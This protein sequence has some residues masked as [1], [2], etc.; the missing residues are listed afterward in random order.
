MTATPMIYE[1]VSEA[2]EHLVNVND[3]L[4]GLEKHEGETARYRVDRVFRAVHSVKGGAGFFGCHRIE[5]LAHLMETLLGRMRQER[6]PVTPALIDALLAGTDRILT[7]LDDVE[8]SNEAEIDDV[9]YRLQPFLGETTPLPASAAPIS[10]DAPADDALDLVRQSGF[11]PSGNLLEERPA[12]HSNLY[13]LHADLGERYR[14]HL[15][16][17]LAFLQSLQKVGCILDA[18]LEVVGE[19][20]QTGMPEGP[21]LYH[22]LFSSQMEVGQLQ[23]A[24][25]LRTEEIVQVEPAPLRIPVI[26]DAAPLIIDAPAD[27]GAVTAPRGGE[28]ASSIRINV[29]LLD[30]LMSLAGEL[31][32]LRNRALQSMGPGDTHLRPIIQRLDGVTLQLQETV[33]LTRM[34]PVAILFGKFPRLIRDL[35]RQLDKEIELEMSGTE[36]ELDKTIL[37]A[38]SDPLT[39]LLRNCCDH[40]IEPPQERLRAGKSRIGLVT[41]RAQHEGGQIRIE[42]RDDG[43]GIDPG[44]L[45]RKALE[46]GFKSPA[47]L[48]RMSDRDAL[49]LILLPGFST[50]QEVT[51]LSGRGVG[52]DVVR[53]NLEPLGG[54][55]DIESVVGQG[56]AFHLR[57]PLTLAIIPCLLVRVGDEVYAIAQKD[58]EELVCI[59]ASQ[60][61]N[62]IEYAHDQEVYRLRDRL[63]P[64]VRLKEVLRRR[65]PF[66]GQTQA[67]ILRQYRQGTGNGPGPR[68]KR[69]SASNH[70]NPL[71]PSL[72]AYERH[73]APAVAKGE[74]VKT[75]VTFER[76]TLASALAALRQNGGPAKPGG[77]PSSTA[78][79]LADQL[80]SFAVVKV[81]ARRFGLIV[82]RILNT[83]EI[84]VKP[85]HAALLSL[86]CYSGATILGDGRVAVI[87]DIEGIARHT[88]VFTMMA[89]ETSVLPGSGQPEQDRQPVLIFK[90]GQREQFG[91]ALAMIR[92]IEMIRPQQIEK[93]GECEFV[94][95]EGVPTRVVRLD[96]FLKVSPF[97]ER[98]HLL[99]LR[100]RNLAKPLGILVSS[101]VDTMSLA[102]ELDTESYREDGILG[103]AQVRGQMTLFLDL[104]RLADMVDPEAKKDRRQVSPVPAGPRRVLLV[105]DTQFFRQVV[106]AYLEGEGYQVQTAVNG[107]E[108]IRKADEQS[109][110]LVVSDIEMPV[111]N[112]W[113]FG[114]KLRKNPR[115]TDVP[116]MALTTLSSEED[117]ARAVECGFD[118]YELKLDRERFLKAVSELMHEKGKRGK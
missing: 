22:A 42:V 77:T 102:I 53:T 99:L 50:A 111:M 95:I 101:I 76:D 110:D 28:R 74:R 5:E 64:L 72:P 115:Y 32:L 65:E 11:D 14:Q 4:L 58:L 37:E 39:H 116:L 54:N 89:Q 103:T 46:N 61:A 19:T 86:P 17:P 92:R 69:P 107:E 93:I 66:T 15:Q 67:E 114:Q 96:R 35:A 84:V 85:M 70:R 7:L 80:L 60:A 38:L 52:M 56:T 40:G 3:D 59:H 81:G 63:L 23:R 71:S 91:V 94:N 112:G 117:R 109:F 30:R 79:P 100:P 113:K 21:I 26:A 48:A 75:A 41:L 104:F 68:T 118:R 51:D 27:E 20:L 47:E 55:L 90:C 62:R 106:K 105:E 34:Q 73:D 98:D 49:N 16:S 108:G 1:F 25:G 87:L 97:V 18:H 13:T 45:K 6:I 31:V 2:K 29:N 9:R 8:H 12:E 83:E 82:D 44:L 33:M 78:V 10:P 57:L 36:V 43:Q 24:V 88:G